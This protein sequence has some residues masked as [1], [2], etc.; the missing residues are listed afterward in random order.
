MAYIDTLKRQ[1]DEVT[2]EFE[3]VSTQE[4]PKVNDALKA[5][6]Q[7]ALAILPESSTGAAALARYFDGTHRKSAVATD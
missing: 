6:G 7:P 3:Q 1:L 5:K 4:L 2:K